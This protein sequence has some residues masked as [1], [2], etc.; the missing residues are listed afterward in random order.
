MSD[1]RS[2]FPFH[3]R[4][5]WRSPAVRRMS[6]EAVGLYVFLLCEQWE[7]GGAIQ[8]D[9]DLWRDVAPPV[10]DFDSAWKAVRPCFQGAG[11]GL[12][13]NLRIEEERGRADS[14]R[15]KRRQAGKASGRARKAETGNTCST[16][17]NTCSTK[18]NTGQDRTGEEKTG[19]REPPNP[20]SQGGASPKRRSG[21]PRWA[22]TVP[23][24]WSP[25]MA[26]GFAEFVRH[27]EEIRKP[28]TPLAGNRLV[29][30]LVELGET[31][32][33][34]AIAH[35]IEHGWQGLREP[36]AGRSGPNGAQLTPAQRALQNL[37]D[38]G[39]FDDDEEADRG[40]S[41]LPD[42]V[43]PRLESERDHHR[44]LPPGAERP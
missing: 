15:E 6:A 33:L 8:D 20:P 1:A 18:T 28:L 9:P 26:E 21:K 44:G 2:W 7:E 22:G 11:P 30:R 13:S 31:R 32:S 23:P 24:S 4:D 39:F 10:V 12:M 14:I 37:Q 16:P 27:R 38:A 5:F 35:T 34:A 40:G 41:G 19:Q 29:K 42:S 43:L 17:A 3:V 36:E 25:Q